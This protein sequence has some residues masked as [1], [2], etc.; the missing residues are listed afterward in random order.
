MDGRHP[1]RQIAAVFPA[2]AVETDF[3][4]HVALRVKAELVLLAV[5]VFHKTKLVFR[6]V[7][8]AEGC[9]ALH[10]GSKLV[11]AAVGETDVAVVVFSMYNVALLIVSELPHVAVGQFHLDD[12]A[13]GIVFI[14]GNPVFGV[15][16]ARAA[17]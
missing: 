13:Q 2:Q 5:F 4:H 10:A 7:A 9:P 1:A 16:V 3:L 15:L 6:I 11:H 17:S 8:E 12:V 14:F